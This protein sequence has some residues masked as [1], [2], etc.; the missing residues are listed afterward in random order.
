MDEEREDNTR[1]NDIKIL[2]V[3]LALRGFSIYG[4]ASSLN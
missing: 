4:A 1:K 3:L 2:K